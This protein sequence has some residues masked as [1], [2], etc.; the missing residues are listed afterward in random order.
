MKFVVHSHG[1]EF[2]TWPTAFRTQV[3]N[4]VI[5]PYISKCI[6]LRTAKRGVLDTKQRILN[7]W[8]IIVQVTGLPFVRGEN[9]I[10]E[11][12]QVLSIK[13]CGNGWL[14]YKYCVGQ[15]PRSGIYIYYT[16][17]FGRLF[18][19]ILSLIKYVCAMS[20]SF[21]E[22]GAESIFKTLFISDISQEIENA[23]HN[24]V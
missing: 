5:S 7:K 17:C 4:S 16:R 11:N 2:G 22:T 8:K 13:I 9:P 3:W 18:Y 19:F 1:S 10:E 21:L 14:L 6:T 12:V 23:Q 24:A 20:N 15:C